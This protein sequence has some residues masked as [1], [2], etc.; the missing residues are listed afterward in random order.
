VDKGMAA[1]KEE[2]KVPILL[3]HNIMVEENHAKTAQD[4]KYNI[5]DLVRYRQA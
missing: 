2:V 1:A 4:L 3:I 5:K